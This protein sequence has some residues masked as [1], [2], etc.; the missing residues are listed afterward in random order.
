MENLTP[1]RI[2]EMSYA[3]FADEILCQYYQLGEK[4]PINPF[5][6]STPEKKFSATL[7]K[8][9]DQRPNQL[10]YIGAMSGVDMV[11]N[12]LANL[13]FQRAFLFD[14]DEKQ[15]QYL[16]LRLSLLEEPAGNGID[17]CLNLLCV[18]EEKRKDFH[19]QPLPDILKK[20]EH[21]QPN[22][23][24]IAE[25][26]K[27]FM[28]NLGYIEGY[29]DVEEVFLDPVFRKK[30][31]LKIMEYIIGM[32]DK[33]T[34][35]SWFYS[36]TLKKLKETLFIKRA[37]NDKFN[38]LKVKAFPADFYGKFPEITK[39]LIA[40]YNMKNLVIRVPDLAIKEKDKQ[41]TQNPRD[42]LEPLYQK[43][44]HLWVILNSHS[45]NTNHA[46]NTSSWYSR[47][48]K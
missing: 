40:I 25:Q 14:R 20:M 1:E 29:A 8:I 33:Q 44:D 47:N 45:E 7:K 2:D 19:N 3:Y 28:D 18:E 12:H 16:G 36:D 4:I 21:Y 34:E 32:D 43:L 9:I 11:F 30:A 17:Y 6:F 38:R 15:T 35:S 23:Q 10:F 41:Y 37:P 39:K 31:A 13:P 27:R 24:R 22:P 26:G 42:W 48:K 5:F 46:F